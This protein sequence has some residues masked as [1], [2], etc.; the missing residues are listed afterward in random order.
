MGLFPHALMRPFSSGS[1]RTACLSTCDTSAMTLQSGSSLETKYAGLRR[2]ASQTSS[3]WRCRSLAPA[4]S[5]PLLQW[6]WTT[7]CLV[8][9]TLCSA[10]LM[11]SAEGEHVEE[12]VAGTAFL[13]ATAHLERTVAPSPSPRDSWRKQR[14]LLLDRQLP[15]PSSHCLP[16]SHAPSGR[17]CSSPPFLVH[18]FWSLCMFNFQAL[19]R[20]F[21]V[22]LPVAAVGQSVVLPPLGRAKIS[23]S[24]DPQVGRIWIIQRRSSL[25]FIF[26]PDCEIRC[27]PRHDVGS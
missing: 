4:A 17:N 20:V 3:S 19:K 23:P 15:L 5:S 8:A 16:I 11:S 7:P 13:G 10:F 27:S 21:L 22:A 14:I 18:I 24:I 2:P 12:A 9:R 6:R 25:Q 1:E 26:N